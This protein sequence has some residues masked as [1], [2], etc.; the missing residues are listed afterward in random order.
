MMHEEHVALNYPF[1]ERH[2]SQA[3]L[4]RV[5]QVLLAVAGRLWEGSRDTTPR[6]VR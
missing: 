2:F 6:D 4:A 5:D 3:L 1:P